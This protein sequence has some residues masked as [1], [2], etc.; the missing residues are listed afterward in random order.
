[1]NNKGFT[2]VEVV[3]A[4]SILGV[5]LVS[6]FGFVV[7]FRDKVRNEEVRT[8]LMDFKN[9]I[10]KV[11]YD[12]I[13]GDKI[14]KIEACLGIQKCVKFTDPIN[15]STEHLLQVVTV[16]TSTDIQKKGLYLNYDGIM[17]MLPDSDLKD[18][19]GYMC[20]FEDFELKSYDNSI[21]DLKITFKHYGIN[22]TYTI[23]LMVN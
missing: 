5:M 21:Y 14:V 12:D 10:T 18:V 20:N 16:D 19:N 13:V 7:Y 6:M 4:F 2:I 17:Y 23:H 1:M 11:V 15:A 22:E 9:T 8:Q 3:I